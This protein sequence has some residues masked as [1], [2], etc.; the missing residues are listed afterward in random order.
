MYLWKFW[1]DT[2]RGVFIYLV[3][4]V[5]G[6][7]LWLAGM[8]KMN[9]VANITD[10]PGS[11]WMLQVG[12]TFAFGYLCALVMAFVTGHNSVGDDIGKGTGD[13]LLTRPRSRGYF[14]WTAWIAGIAEM[15]ALILTTVF[16]VFALS[17]LMMGAAWRHVASPLHFTPLGNGQ[18]GILDMPLMVATIVLTAVVVYSLTYFLSV[19]SRSGQRG[20]L[21]S[22]AILF[23]YSILSAVLKQFA[24]ITLP[25]VNLADAASHGSEA[26]YLAPSI[27]IIGWMVL[28]IAFPFAAQMSLDRADI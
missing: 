17:V 2:R 7:V 6:A 25:S 10:Q 26:W 5:V 19:A 15:A 11:V 22:I 8:Y 23:A 24:G 20:I 21:G 12:G 9:R 3:L 27:Q 1:R 4:L 13:F 16:V 28:S 18:S 14:V